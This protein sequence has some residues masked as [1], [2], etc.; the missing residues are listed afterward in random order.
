MAKKPADSR[1]K[2]P[3]GAVLAD[4]RESIKEYRKSNAWLQSAEWFDY[5]LR[6][7]PGK[8]AIAS[9][10][11]DDLTKGQRIYKRTQKELDFEVLCANVLYHYQRCK[12][13]HST[14]VKSPVAI[15]LNRNDWTLNRYR[16]VSYFTMKAVSLLKEN[17]L[18]ERK[19]GY[20]HEIK[21]YAQRT[22]IWPTKKL[23]EAFKPV[24]MED[25]IFDPVELVFLRNE[26][27]KPIG[28]RDT[29]E[30]KRVREFLRKANIVNGQALV[31]Y[32]DP[33]SREKYRLKS[34][35]YCVYNVDLKHG[36]RFFASGLDRY[37]RFSEEDREHIQIDH[38]PTIELDFSGL[39]PRLLYAWE[40]IQYD[41]DPYRAV[42][43]DSSLRPLIKDLLLRL[44][45]ADNE[46]KAVRAGNNLLK[47]HRE[48]YILIREHGLN[49]KNDLI[50]MLKAAHKPISKYF[51]TGVGMKAMN[52]DS[53]I[54]LD[55]ITHFVNDNIPILVIHD[56]FVV[57]HKYKMQL[58]RVMQLAYKKHTGGFTCK[59][60]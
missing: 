46:V 24:R 58:R 11:L 55:V 15:S 42:T 36:G 14:K 3:A 53:K 4:A 47:E 60:K 18:I 59:I 38:E 40:G 5:D 8:R 32:V 7:A 49:V 51:C 45:N 10:L 16:R 29:R 28:Y 27:K 20:G 43:N 37:Q 52:T 39:H 17:N 25:F 22:K 2:I 34:H 35:L 33:E 12:F 19:K 48:Y 56:S 50:P 41:D 31:Q 44:L 57:Q 21:I 54:A 1:K 23:L 6:L 9:R 30:T 26:D 13:F